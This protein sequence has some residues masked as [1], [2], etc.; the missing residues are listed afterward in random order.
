MYLR[1]FGL[2]NLFNYAFGSFPPLGE[3]APFLNFFLLTIVQPNTS[4]AN[5]SKPSTTASVTIAPITP[6]T[7]GLMPLEQ[8]PLLSSVLD[9]ELVESLVAYGSQ[10]PVELPQ[11]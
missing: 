10:M 2:S 5:A 11:A 4:I 6:L 1:S 8:P 3:A 9:C 7:A